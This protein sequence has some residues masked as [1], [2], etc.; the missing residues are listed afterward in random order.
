M[1]DQPNQRARRHSLMPWLRAAAASETDECLP[2]P[3]HLTIYGYGQVRLDGK[4]IGAHRVAFELAHGPVPD[5]LFVLH[6]CLRSRACCN[7]RHLY[8]GTQADNTADMLRDGT[9]ATG[10]RHG[11]HTHPESRTVGLR[12]GAHTHP[13]R[14]GGATG[15]RHGTKTHPEQIARGEAASGSRLTDDQVRD[16]R[17]R[18]TLGGVTYRDLAAAF[19]VSHVSILKIVTRKTWSHL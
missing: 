17:Q 3:G 13:D 15:E 18:Y 7:P 14:R 10:I 4:A 12:S 8:A 1:P 6:R 11:T 2:F 9:A 5:G 16:I 19:G